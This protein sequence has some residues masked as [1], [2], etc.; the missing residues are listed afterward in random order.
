[1]RDSADVGRALKFCLPTYKIQSIVR[2]G[3]GQ[4]NVAYEVNGELIV[5]FRKEPHAATR[6]SLV[7]RESRLLAGVSNICPV[8]APKPE[9]ILENQGCLVYS[10]IPGESLVDVTRTPAGDRVVAAQL[11]EVLSALHGVP[12]EQ[13]SHLVEIDHEPL[14]VWLRDV[15]QISDQVRSAI[16]SLYREAVESFVTAPT[17][18]SDCQLVFSHNDL[19][20]E[21]ILVD[22]VTWK[23]SGIIDWGDAAICDPAYDF[24]LILRDLG[25]ACLD[26]ALGRYSSAINNVGSVRDR[27]IFY[28]RCSSIE[29]LAYG[30][31]SG[32]CFYVDNS[33]RALEWLFPVN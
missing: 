28:G 31:G 8:P 20:I 30:I 21:H 14:E 6:A 3:E 27:A 16:P 29:D 11:G 13:M 32:K 2:I 18:Q 4:E 12:V 33:M 19:G 5:R 1:M 25:P 23:I 17:P 9:F 10:K 7:I 22:P 15:A 24:G 26:E